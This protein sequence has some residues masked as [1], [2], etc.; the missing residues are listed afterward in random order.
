MHRRRAST[1]VMGQHMGNG[2][3]HGE[4][5]GIAKC[6]NALHV[7][8]YDWHPI[9]SNQSFH[10]ETSS[11]HMGHHQRATMQSASSYQT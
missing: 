10:A 5:A 6:T 8:Y 11:T 1:W 4:W 3:A 7:I 2:P 9:L